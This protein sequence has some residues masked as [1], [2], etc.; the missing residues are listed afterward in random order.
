LIPAA[1]R[2]ALSAQ[3]HPTRRWEETKDTWAAR[4][5]QYIE[6]VRAAIDAER[7]WLKGDAQEPDWPEFPE[8]V[9][10][11]RRGTCTDGDHAP[12]HPATAKW[13]YQEVYTQRAALWLRQLTQNSRERDS[14]WPAI[15]VETYAAWTARAN[16]AGCEESAETNNQADNWNGVFFR[17]LARTLL[18]SDLDHASSQIV[19]AIAVPDR[20]F[21]DIAEIL[22]PALDELHFNDLGLDLGMALR[23]R[24]H[25]ADRLM[26]TAGWRRER[27]RSEMSVEMRIGPAIGVLFFNRYS[28]FGGSHCYL[29]E[30]GIDRVDSFFPQ[31]TRLIQDGSVPFTALLTMNLLEVSPRSEHTAFFLSSA[32]TW[33]QKQPNNKPLWVDGGLG[34]R[35]AQWLELAAAS[36]ATLRATTHP[37]RAQVDDLL[38]RLVRVGVAEA[39]RVER[40]LAQPTSPNE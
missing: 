12:K 39:H 16:G 21:F 14:E 34:A 30:K 26:R 28:S 17:L 18:G 2:C 24:G 31:I 33:L 1:L 15:L 23:L 29:L 32:L 22:V 36:D 7:A 27:E 6:R 19:R 13:E 9:L 8:P 4:K 35:L 38:A 11:I 20:S 5:A 10:N 25:I 3:I 40:A 37:L